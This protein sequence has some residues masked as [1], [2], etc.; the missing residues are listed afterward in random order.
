MTSITTLEADL[1]RRAGGKKPNGKTITFDLKG[2]GKLRIDGKA[3][4]IT[5]TRDDAP[6]DA[7]ITI[8]VDDLQGL[9]EGRLSPE[10]LMLTGRAKMAGNPL[11]VMKLRDL[12]S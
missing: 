6:S 4:P 2:E 10:P 7:T 8:S 11:A 9:I 3:D 12:L 5:V 1:Q